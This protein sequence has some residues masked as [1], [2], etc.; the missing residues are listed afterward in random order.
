MNDQKSADWQAN[1]YL[2]DLRNTAAEN[3][4]KPDEK[5]QLSLVTQEDKAAI[6]KKYHAAVA[7]KANPEDL[8][9]MFEIVKI[10]LNQ[11]AAII[12]DIKTIGRDR[13]QYL[14]AYNPEREKR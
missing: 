3:G 7:A 8:S 1:E 14:I 11:P 5:W 6:E 10:R 9:A 2:Y 13:L 12:P 4:F